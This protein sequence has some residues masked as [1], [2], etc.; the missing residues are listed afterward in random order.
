MQ[1]TPVAD[2]VTEA[3]DDDGAVGGD[4]TPVR[5]RLLAKVREEVPGGER[6]EVVVAA[7]TLESLGIRERDDLPRGTPD[8][9]PELERSADAL[10][11]PE[12]NGTRSA[13]CRRDENAVAGDLLD[14]PGRGAEHEG[15]PLPRLVD[16]LLVE[17]TDAAAIVD[18]EDAEEATIGDRAGV[19][20]S[21]PPGSLPTL[22]DTRRAVP[23][24]A[25]PQLGEFVGRVTPREHVEHVLE[26]RS[27]QTGERVRAAHE[28]VQIVDGDLVVGADR[29]DLLGEHV[30]WVPGNLSL[31][32]QALA[33]RLRHDCGLQ[34]VGAE[35]RED[36]ALRDRP[37][38][39]TGAADALQ[40]ACDRFRALDLDHEVDGSHVYPELERRGCDEARDQPGFQQLLDLSTLLARERAVVG[41]RNGLVGELVETHGEPLGQ[42]PVVDEHDGGAVLS[43]EVEQGGVDRRPDRPRRRLVA[44][45]HLHAVRQHGQGQVRIRTGLPHVLESDDHLEI[46]L[47]AGAG[48]DQLDRPAAGHEASDLL[49]G[50]LRRGKADALERLIRDPDE[51]LER[52]RQVGPALGACDGVNLVHDDRL[53]PTQHLPALRGEKEIERLGRRDQD[54]RRSAQ[55]LAT[56]ALVRVTC[57]NSDRQR[58]AEPRERSSQVAF[59]VVIEC[60]QR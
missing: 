17:L 46:E 33:H 41:A 8:L 49:Q 50:T 38:V 26:L 37:E 39:V 22:D 4:H 44:G 16:H 55:H 13:R 57:A 27:G 35:L 19:R 11:L 51:A 2:L 43:Y 30:E 42:P 21:Q 5:G 15:L 40:P 24:D 18:L 60:L 45:G 52:D 48:V 1:T 6:I 14:P 3:L 47:L 23:H 29:D 34:Q 28:L 9:L 56:L 25:R 10:A 32:D 53:D 54:V 58:R 36:S 31:L 20:D 7:E 12:R 59:D